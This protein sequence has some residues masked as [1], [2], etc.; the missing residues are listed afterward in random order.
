MRE[1]GPLTAGAV[2]VQ[3]RVHDLA[4]IVPGRPA[5]IQGPAAV[6]EAP[7][8]QHRLINP[9]RASDRSL[10]YARRSVMTWAYRRSGVCAQAC[11]LPGRSTGQI[12]A[13]WNETGVGR[14]LS[15][16]PHHSP[17]QS[18]STRQTSQHQT[19]SRRRGRDNTA[20]QKKTTSMWPTQA[21]SH[22]SCD[23]ALQLAG[24]AMYGAHPEADL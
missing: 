13:S 8:G 2:H 4:Q 15:Q 14:R 19:I 9:Q 3:N 17:H 12:R 5:E 16:T 23:C 18:R 21:L 10:G 7:G 22:T 6:L 1:V 24:F 20:L 11:V